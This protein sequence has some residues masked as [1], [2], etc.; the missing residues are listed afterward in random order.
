LLSNLAS[1]CLLLK[2]CLFLDYNTI[3]SSLTSCLPL[4]CVDVF[5]IFFLA[6]R[7]P[8]A[9]SKYPLSYVVLTLLHMARTRQ[10]VC[11]STRGPPHP[12]HHPLEVPDQE[13]P[14]Q[15][16]DLPVFAVVDDDDDDY[17]G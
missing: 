1:A 11:K 5:Q 15:P 3:I 8:I 13:E 6:L 7:S 17:Y 4:K 16:E 10:T 9:F 2:N 14:E 12:I